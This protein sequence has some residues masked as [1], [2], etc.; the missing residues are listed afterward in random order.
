MAFASRTSEVPRLAASVPAADVET[1]AQRGVV[2]AN[3]I[4]HTDPEAFARVVQM[5]G[6]GSLSVPITRTFTFDELPQA[7]RLVGEERSRGKFAI[8]IAS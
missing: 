7:L 8:T 4:G 2:A 3:V 1:L 6:D 5:A